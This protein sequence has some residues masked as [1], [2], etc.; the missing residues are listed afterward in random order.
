LALRDADLRVRAAAAASLGELEDA[1][2]LRPLIDTLRDC[3]VGRAARPDFWFGVFKA[4]TMFV[5]LVVAV[6]TRG[7]A[8]RQANEMLDQYADS[9]Q[10]RNDLIHSITTA[11]GRIGERHPSAELRGVLPDL[12]VVSQDIVQQRRGTRAMSR[13][14]AARIEMLTGRLQ[15][16][17]LPAVD[18]GA[19]GDS[20]PH[21][22]VEPGQHWPA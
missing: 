21:P 18:L 7:R 13:Q 14:T 4:F 6:M 9:R 11:I 12:K 19:G 5:A 16:L 22:S 1:R 20:L 8:R 3:F 17:P 15:D 10:R 2:A